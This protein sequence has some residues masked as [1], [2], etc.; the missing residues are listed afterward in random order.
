[1]GVLLALVAGVA[2]ALWWA[3]HTVRVPSGPGPS[4]RAPV[5]APP[6]PRPSMPAPPNLAATDAPPGVTAEQWAGLKQELAA[7]PQELQRLAGYFSFSDALERYRSSKDQLPAAERQ[8]LARTLD[9]GLDERLRQR[10]LNI[11]EAQ[12]IKTAVLQEL[13]ADDT[14]RA[15]ALARWRNE[16]AGANPPAT[17]HRAREQEFLQQQAALVSAWQAQPVAQRDPLALER[18]LDAL[19][20]ASF[21][22]STDTPKEATR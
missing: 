10:E 13:L 8:A 19:R 15:E 5:E 11:G 2:M 6:Q 16:Q 20:R 14:Q 7:R 1:M 9:A 12:K 22:P 21:T 17:A 4:G 3:P 18:E